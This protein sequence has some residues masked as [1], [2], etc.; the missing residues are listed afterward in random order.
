MKYTRICKI[1][2]N[3]FQTDHPTKLTCSTECS[4]RNKLNSSKAAEKRRNQRKL[5]RSKPNPAKTQSLCLSCS[6][7]YAKPFCEGG[8][9]KVL[10]GTKVYKKAHWIFKEPKKRAPYWVLVVEECELYEPDY[11]NGRNLEVEED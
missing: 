7:A 3:E 8:C 11:L 6:R 9:D 10:Y 1:C 4:T 2:D 5:K